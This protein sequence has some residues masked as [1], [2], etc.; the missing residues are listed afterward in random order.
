M[1]ALTFWMESSNSH[2]IHW[3]SSL[4]LEA[5][6]CFR[7]WGCM[8]S[9]PLALI[10]TLLGAGRN[11]LF[12]PN[13]LLNSMGLNACR[14]KGGWA[15]CSL[16]KQSEFLALTS[17]SWGAMSWRGTS[18]VPLASRSWLFYS[19]ALLGLSAVFLAEVLLGVS[20]S[21]NSFCLFP[22]PGDLR[23]IPNS[24]FGFS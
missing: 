13:L 3:P 16:E 10:R 21:V 14:S 9:L 1:P 8:A 24:G 15:S 4:S 11:T 23:T 6:P 20:L 12:C 19:V 7:P 2:T 22:P 17:S 18:S 5:G